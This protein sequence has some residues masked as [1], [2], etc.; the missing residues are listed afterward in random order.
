M[1]GKQG[2]RNV[3][4][5]LLLALVVVPSVRAVLFE[6]TGD[7]S[8]N[9]NPPTGSLTN[10]GWQYEGLWNTGVDG[11]NYLGTPI[12]P[13]FFAAAQHIGGTNGETFVYNG[14]TYHTVASFDCPNSDLR[15]WQVAET[16][17]GYAP[18]YTNSN[19]VGSLCVAIGRGTQRGSAVVVLPQTNGWEYGANDMV[20]RWG[21]N[22]VASIYTDP[23]LGQFLYCTFDRNGTSNECQLSTGDS[24]G[25]MFIEDGGTWKLA[26]LHYSVDGPFS[27]DGTANTQFMGAL[28]DLR[29]LYY[30]N[31]TGGWTFVS[32]SGPVVPS[33][34]YSTR[35]SAHI[36]WINGV[37]SSNGDVAPV[38]GFE[39]APTFGQWPLS[40]TFTDTSTGTV[41]NRF[42]DFG[43]NATT[44]TLANILTHTYAGPGTNTVTLIV[45]GP[46]G[47]STNAQTNLVVVVN[48][49]HLSVQPTSIAWGLVAVGQSTN[50]QFFVTNT[51][52]ET[53]TGT[54]QVNTAGSPFAV[55]SGSPFNVA[56]GQTGL[57]SVSFSPLAV[58]AFTNS[59]VFASNGG[60]STNAVTGSA[61]ITPTAGFTAGP[62]NG[63]A[64]LLVNFTDASSGTV[65]SRVWDFGDGGTSTLASP[66]HTYSNA[67]TYSV[68]LTVLGPL[69]S[70]TLL[71]AN[72]I[73][74]TNVVP[75]ASFLASPTAGA[76]P[77]LV[78]FTDTST[79]IVTNHSWTFGDGN[80]SAA[81]SPSHTYSTA[82][83]Y[84]VA[85]TVS[86]P[87]GSGMT[88]QAN[89]ITVT[90]VV[91]TPPTVSIVRPANGMLYPPVTNLTITIVA[92]ATANDGG[93]ISRIEF[94]AD[95]TKLGQTT[96]N[97]G[98][99]FLVH[100]TLGTHTLTA[101]AT[102]SLLASNTS[103]GVTI[104]VGARNSPLGDWEVR[105]SGA[106][107]G[108]GFLTFE[109]DFSASGYEIRL[110]PFGLDDVSGTW[111][112][113]A[114]GVI[115]GSLVEQ[116][117]TTTNWNGTL[118]G[119][120]TSLKSLSASVTTTNAGIF[121]W[122]GVPATT[123]PDLSGT[124]TGVVT[125]VK[126]PTSVSYAVRTNATDSAVFDVTASGNTNAVIG[127]LIATSRNVVYGY[128]TTGGTNITMSGKFNEKKDSLTFKGTDA[129]ADKV[130][131]QLFK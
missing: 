16:F 62:T 49:P 123:F 81:V 10:S 103:A 59:V 68:S 63:A 23:N 37:I 20:Q 22:N 110:K 2:K 73:T 46:V 101:I 92:S 114:K 45:G 55:T 44:N 74:A 67:G 113:G 51:G 91:N 131:I 40:V 12:A 84:S 119:K 104:T 56:G 43:D 69:G 36:D 53:L 54:A 19:E 129:T 116:T 95:G 85:L 35:I 105:I 83:V 124:W 118:A 5:G 87:G 65:T 17:P 18:L 77:L 15:L 24:S 31:S 27:L 30:E 102:D 71:Q 28:L 61:D 75:V 64:P 107:K 93:T 7:P 108:V 117:G 72:Y 4:L 13:L 120:A 98:T 32:T 21:V 94:F 42:W 70:N 8:Y 11:Y 76:T 88:N 1:K 99:N 86:G 125:I 115:T 96:S 50:Q 121:K 79:G 29:G 89:L 47:V 41:T 57:V 78:S 112:F 80:T 90:N 3:W 128:V 25:G 100:P 127:Q 97:P 58:G 26:G 66:S 111:G 106:D 60:V 126:S 48:P 38:A 122:K 34:F 130:S 6:A 109:D 52:D 33:G 14:F 9:T 82:G 39:A